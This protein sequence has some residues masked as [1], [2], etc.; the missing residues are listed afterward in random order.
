MQH[1]PAGS[2]LPRCVRVPSKP[3][4][5]QAKA[6]DVDVVGR[7]EEGGGRRR[8]CEGPAFLDGRKGEGGE[9]Y[10]WP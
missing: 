3:N 6:V 9:V 5:S 2:A 10:Y 4:L 1:P 7:R 8:R